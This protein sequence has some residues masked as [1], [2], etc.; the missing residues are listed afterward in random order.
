M[1][2]PVLVNVTASFSDAAEV[3]RSATILSTDDST[4][5]A[6]STSITRWLPP[7]RSSPSDILGTLCLHQSG[8]PAD[9]GVDGTNKNSAIATE[10]AISASLH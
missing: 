5:L 3:C 1:S 9:N 6:V 4:A 10:R 7:L 2:W 8:S